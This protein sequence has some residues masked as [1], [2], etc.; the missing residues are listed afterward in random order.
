M[1]AA[2]VT[3]ECVGQDDDRIL[4]SFLA[5]SRAMPLARAL[6]AVR[7]LSAAAKKEIFRAAFRRMEFFD[8]PPRE[9]EMAE[10]TVQAVISSSCFAQ[11]KRHRLATLLVGPYSPRWGVT[12][13]PALRWAGLEKEF[14]RVIAETEKIFFQFKGKYGGAAD[15]L[16]TNAHRR[17]VLLKM[18]LRELYHFIRLRDDDNAQWDIRQLAATIG[19]QVKKQLPLSSLLLCGKSQFVREFRKIYQR[20]PAFKI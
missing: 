19:R 16:L 18:N 14:R 20:E 6:A 1:S 13:P 15:Y 2:R 9:F 3:V 10:V 4:A 8:A 7:R 12:V 17:P 5:C 11:L